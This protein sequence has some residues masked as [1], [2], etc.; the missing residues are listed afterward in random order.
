[1]AADFRLGAPDFLRDE[2]RLWWEADYPEVASIWRVATRTRTP[3][4]GYLLTWSQ[5]GANLPAKYW[6]V[7]GREAE[8]LGQLDV[9]GDFT[10]VL[11]YDADVT[12]EDHI[13]LTNSE[14]GEA[15]HF[16][17]TYVHKRSR[18]QSLHVTCVE[19]ED[20]PPLQ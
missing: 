13:L 12:E 17:V 10:V 20:E 3:D 11:P 16:Q 4:M 2:V 18:P 19:Y 6:S 14:T 1:V 5:P 15:H 9:Q 7:T 8:A